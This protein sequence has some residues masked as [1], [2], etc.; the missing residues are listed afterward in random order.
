M[1]RRFGVLA[2]QVASISQGVPL[3]GMHADHIIPVKLSGSTSMD[4]CQLLTPS[5]NLEKGTHYMEPRDWQ[6]EFVEKWDARK[7][8]EPFLLCAIPG[9]GKTF[10]ALYVAK[11][12]LDA[13]SDRAVVVVCPTDNLKEQWRAEAAKLGIQLETKGIDSSF[14]HGFRGRCSTYQAV[15]MS[16]SAHVLASLCKRRHVMVILDEPH[17]CGE[18]IAWGESCSIAFDGAEEKLLLSGTPWRQD[19]RR[20]PFV[21]YENGSVVS[22]FRYDYPDAL[23]DR[24]VRY[25]A[26]EYHRGAAELAMPEGV[27][28]RYN[29]N[30]EADEDEAALAVRLALRDHTGYAREMLSAANERL[31][32]LRRIVPDAAGL[33]ACIDQDHA[34]SM[35]RVLESITG[36]EP[37]KILSGTDRGN[38]TVDEFR[39]STSPWLVAVKQVSEGTDIKRL[40]LLCYMTTAATPLFFRQLV[41]RVSRVR[42]IPGD[43]D[44]HVIIPSTAKLRELVED[45]ERWQ[46]VVL[47]EEREAQE[48]EEI[49]RDDDNSDRPVFLGSEYSGVEM[50]QIG[51]IDYTKEQAVKIEGLARKFDLDL[52]TAAKI[53]EYVVAGDESPSVE[54]NHAKPL[55]Q[56]MDEVRSKLKRAV[57]VVHKLT[58]IPHNEIN[59]KYS[60]RQADMTLPQLK[61]KLAD[62]KRWAD[63]ERSQKAVAL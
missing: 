37:K 24:V 31:M 49:E 9:G 53:L 2:R 21:Q 59:G 44:A 30:Q 26:F 11:R 32:E 45:I 62:L 12:W 54:V 38:T 39:K 16:A 4:N 61:N 36:Q 5:A 42:G 55:E 3:E 29:I 28:E 63:R 22:H 52:P 43:R 51:G 50:T 15:A 40:Q 33:V 13:A 35:A 17:H 58:G 48:R 46:E 8:G 34:D 60:P 18:A 10:A 25:L 47:R 6:V 57:N 27:S 19:G 41:G 1:A 7:S 23:R 56:E 14:K 20:I